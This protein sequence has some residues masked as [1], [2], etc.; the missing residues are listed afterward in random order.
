MP[1]IRIHDL[2]H[3]AATLIPGS[4]VP[5]PLVSKVLRHSQLS[6]TSGLYGHLTPEIARGRLT[7][8]VRRWMRPGWSGPR[9][10][11]SPRLWRRST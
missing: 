4:G 6:I 8:T 2:R 11:R 1:R 9:S 7:R 3:T 5:L 10:R